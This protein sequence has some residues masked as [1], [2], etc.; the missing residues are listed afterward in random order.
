MVMV[1]PL[2]VIPNPYNNYFYFPRYVILAI[3]SIIIIYS[4]LREKVRFNLRHPVFIPLGFFLLFGLLSTVLAPYPFTAWVGF[5]IYEGTTARFTGFSTC[6]F[7]AL[8]FLIAYNTKQSKNIL[9]YMVITATIVSFLGLLQ[10][11]GINFIP[12]E[13][14]R[15]GIR[16]YSTMGNPNFFGTYTVFILPATMLL[17]FFTGK[18]QWLISTAL[19]YSGLLICVTRGVWIAFFFAFIVISVYILRHK[20]MRKKY[21]TMVFLLI[22]VTGILLPTSN[23]LIYKRIFSIPD[24]IEASVKMEDDGGSYRI[25]IWKESAKLIP[26]NW[27]FGIGPEHLGYADIR[28]KINLADKVHNVYLEIIVTMGAFAFLSY[29]LF[30]G[31]FLK[32]WKNEFGLIYF[33]MI[34]SYLLQGIFNIDVIMVMP[35][36]WIVLGLSLSNEKHL[37]SHIYT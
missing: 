9:Y 1:Y 6:I 22:I 35:L 36:F 3:I 19:I 16:S 12:H 2:I 31:Y 26:Q 27:A 37:K 30:L 14:F 7:C 4:I 25:Y 23:G 8:L 5:D 34:F 17:Y 15:T 18:K 29:I 24:Q 28:P 33:I 11:F 20:D 13:D 21:L 10:H 32:P